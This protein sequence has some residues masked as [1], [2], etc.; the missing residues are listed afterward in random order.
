M[1]FYF[2]GG[3]ELL[4]GLSCLTKGNTGCCTENHTRGGGGSAGRQDR[5]LCSKTGQKLHSLAQQQVGEQ[6]VMRR[7]RV[8][9]YTE[10]KAERMCAGI[11]CGALEKQRREREL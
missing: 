6:V 2:K 8:Q 11:G 9:M 7:H 4:A 5:R 1:G 10:G 3:G